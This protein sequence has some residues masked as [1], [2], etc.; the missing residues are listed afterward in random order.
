MLRA[1]ATLRVYTLLTR[2]LCF[3]FP[4]YKISTLPARISIYPGV[5]IGPLIGSHRPGR[6]TSAAGFEHYDH[7][8]RELASSLLRGS[9]AHTVGTFVECAYLLASLDVIVCWLKNKTKKT[10][11]ETYYK[12]V[13]NDI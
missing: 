11:N 2:E 3:L 1:A 8:S 12:C 7:R 10:L 9:T 5:G 13:H 6:R 4:K